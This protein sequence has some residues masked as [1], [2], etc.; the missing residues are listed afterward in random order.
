[1]HAAGGDLDEQVVVRSTIRKQAERE[2]GEQRQHDQR[3]G[4]PELLADDREDEVVVRLGQPRPLL[5]AG[6]EAERPTSR[7]RPAP[8]ARGSACQH[9]LSYGSVRAL[10]RPARSAPG[11][12]GSRCSVTQ[13]P[14]ATAATSRAA[15]R[16]QPQRRA[17]HEQHGG[18]QRHQDQ[19]RCRG[20]AR[21]APAPSSTSAA[22]GDDRARARAPGGAAAR[23]CAPAPRRAQTTSAELG[24]LR[25]L[26]RRTPPSSIQLRLPLTATPS[27]REHQ[28]LARPAPPT[29]SGQASAF[30]AAHRQPRGDARISGSADQRRTAPACGRRRTASRC[31]RTTRRSSWTAP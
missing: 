20:R 31:R 28:Q 3:A 26:Q 23:A 2:H 21:A 11:P 9:W 14:R 13:T 17:G 12:A 4:Q 10:R 1:M 25:G 29:S 16:E 15:E 30:Q 22:T 24:R 5:P 6:A 18:D 27:G 8:T 7:R 19:R